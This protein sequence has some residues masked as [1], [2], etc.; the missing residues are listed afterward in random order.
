[1][2]SGT[3]TSRDAGSR[4]PTSHMFLKSEGAPVFRRARDTGEGFSAGVSG[5]YIMKTME[6]LEAAADDARHEDDDDEP[7][8]SARDR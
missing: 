8:H 6:S 7:Y 4:P 3:M 1:M 2:R 5:R